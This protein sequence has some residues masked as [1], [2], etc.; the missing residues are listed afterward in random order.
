MDL[1]RDRS[2]N[3]IDRFWILPIHFRL[4]AIGAYVKNREDKM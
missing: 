3:G 1:K 2:Q 4:S